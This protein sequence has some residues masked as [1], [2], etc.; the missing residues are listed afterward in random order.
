MAEPF[1][2]L[3]I[4]EFFL[5]SS[6]SMHFLWAT[7]LP[8][9]W[10]EVE[11]GT[12]F[13]SWSLADE[14]PK[15]MGRWIDQVPLW[16]LCV[17]FLGKQGHRKGKDTGRLN[18]ILTYHLSRTGHGIIFGLPYFRRTN[19]GAV[20]WMT[21]SSYQGMLWFLVYSIVE[22]FSGLMRRALRKNMRHHATSESH[23]LGPSECDGGENHW[24]TITTITVI[25]QRWIW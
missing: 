7:R 18:D 16:S 12:K 23:V 6:E 9:C 24:H 11:R 17:F 2:I 13:A 5:S 15:Q 8:W 22:H 14:K 10:S 20:S 21:R 25:I 1:L 3:V 19:H 4:R